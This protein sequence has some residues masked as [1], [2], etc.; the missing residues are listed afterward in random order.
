MRLLLYISIASTCLALA[1]AAV[2]IGFAG[3]TVPANQGGNPAVE[4]Y[5]RGCWYSLATGEPRG[6]G[7]FP[8]GFFK[9]SK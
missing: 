2:E 1:L 9:E 7:E 3:G 6:C 8:P 4:Y 5:E